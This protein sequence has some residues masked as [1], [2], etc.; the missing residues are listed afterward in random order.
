[1]HITGGK[2]LKSLMLLYQQIC[3]FVKK[4]IEREYLTSH[5]K[6]LIRFSWSY[7]LKG[8]KLLS[9]QRKARYILYLQIWFHTQTDAEYIRDTKT[10]RFRPLALNLNHE[11]IFAKNI[12]V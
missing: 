5:S 6:T 11:Y 10:K 7:N 3:N 8:Q 9:S 4:F 2:S 1:M 12:Y